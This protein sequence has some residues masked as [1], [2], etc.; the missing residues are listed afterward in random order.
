MPPMTAVR[1]RRH[2]GGIVEIVD[3][4]ATAIACYVQS[5]DRADE[6]G[7]MLLGRLIVNSNDVMVDEATIP[8]AHD[9]RSR[10]FFWRARKPAQERVTTAWRESG[11]TRIY[12][13]DWHTH[14][15]DDPTPSCK[16]LKNGRRILEQAR[17]EQDFLLFLIAGLKTTRAWE[18]RKSGS[19]PVE[20]PCTR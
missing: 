17:F 5:D 20:M 15:E 18:Y 13:G 19:K 6:G 1:F 8:C 11:Q 14:P 3:S 2:N 12:L 4:A 7:G 16:D 10:F 9:R